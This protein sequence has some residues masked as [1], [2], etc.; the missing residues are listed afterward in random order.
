LRFE[1]EHH[2][3]F[4]SAN[5]LTLTGNL[6]TTTTIDGFSSTTGLFVGE[7]VTGSGIAAGTFITAEVAQDYGITDVDGKVIP[8]LRA[9]RGSPIWRPIP[10]PG[11]GR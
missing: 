10:E 7:T 4:N 11:H 2:V 3:Q 6:H 9:E 1:E 5:P 8:S